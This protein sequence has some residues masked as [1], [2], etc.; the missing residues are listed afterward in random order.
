MHN[1]LADIRLRR[2]GAALLKGGEAQAAEVSCKA[3][4]VLARAATV[5]L[6]SGAHAP[7]TSRSAGVMAD[8]DRMEKLVSLAKT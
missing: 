2:S 7:S 5:P 8:N 4:G 1:H 3:S 6:T